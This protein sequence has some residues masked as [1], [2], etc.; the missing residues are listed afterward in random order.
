MLAG[1]P[2]VRC[3]LTHAIVHCVPCRSSALFAPFLARPSW[4]GSGRQATAT[5]RRSR[6]DAAPRSTDHG[7][8]IENKL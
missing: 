5:G 8:I 1:D 2:V 6:I 3:C 4:T 7:A